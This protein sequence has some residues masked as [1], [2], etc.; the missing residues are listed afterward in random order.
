MTIDQLYWVVG[1][2]VAIV[3]YPWRHQLLGEI[4]T[5][6]L[7]TVLHFV[8]VTVLW[9]AIVLAAAMVAV[10][11]YRDQLRRSSDEDMSR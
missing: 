1:L 2:G 10:K 3:A 8:M 11:A 6:R 5:R 7:A 4:S 9:P